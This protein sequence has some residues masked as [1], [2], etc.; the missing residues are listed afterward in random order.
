MSL[1]SPFGTG[2]A[3]FALFL[4][5]LMLDPLPAAELPPPPVAATIPKEI[6]THGDKRIDPYFWLRE[7]TNR[8]VLEYLA[9]ENAYA[10]KMTAGLADLRAK[11]YEELVG[12]LKEDD[13]SAPVQR[14]GYYYYSRTIK[15]KNYPVFCRKKGSLDAPE[16]VIL[17]ANDMAAGLDFFSVGAFA[18][19]DDNRW[20][21][22]STDTNGYRQYTLRVRDLQTG[23]DL[24][25]RVERTGSVAWAPDNRTIYFSR[26][27]P[28]TKRSDEAHRIKV[29]D[30][31]SERL[32]FEPD[33]L[34]DISLGRSSDRQFILI[35][36]T[37]KR[38][39][40][41]RALP[42]SGNDTTLR[43]LEPRAE[44]HEYDADHAH[45]RFYIRTNLKAKNFRVMTAP[46]GQ[47][48]RAHWQ[49]LIPHDLKV[50]IEGISLFQRHLVLSRRVNGLEE[51]LVREIKSG[52]EHVIAMSDPAYALGLEANPNY[53]THRVRFQYQSPA[54]PRAV[55]EYDMDARTHTLIKQTE[56]PGYDAAPY[57]V[58]RVFARASDG[59]RIPCTVF[60]PK[61]LARNGQNPMLLYGYGS[62]GISIPSGFSSRVLPLLKRGF[63]FAIAHIRGGGEM[64]EEWRDQGRMEHKRTT[65]NDFIACAEHFIGEK[66]TSPERLAIQGGSAGGLLMGAVVNARPDLFR[67]MVAEVPFVDVLNT[68]LDAS[69]PL[70]TS[71]YIEWG[72]PN[73]EKEYNDIKA[74]SPYDNLRAQKYPAMLVRVSL[75]DSQV[76]YWEGAKWVARLRTLKTDQNPL[77]LKTEMGAGHSG[78][79]GRYDSLREEAW[80]QAFVIS[81]VGRP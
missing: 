55:F 61:G 2:F 81:Q 59:T 44:E 16:D 36:S 53:E 72:N 64:G 38:S 35:A 66:Y 60:Q 29:G 71:E 5:A 77:L 48:G 28:V 78:P 20:L 21:A 26:E 49:E 12:H 13:T 4:S 74:Y 23:Q 19:S 67:A 25:T 41:I 46:D 30:L 31:E 57:E 11:L 43:V 40:E 17:D 32:Y 73:V 24:P 15:G 7:K 22:Y 68:M 80:E 42:L 70:T 69:L 50:K 6:V 10:E 79:S 18:P 45:G 62:Y 1:R 47:T 58:D 76:P 37:S 56:V 65:F 14:G 9:A 63:V 27:H 54:K 39:S 52:Q 3:Y 51:L 34:F 33:E 75:N 8:T